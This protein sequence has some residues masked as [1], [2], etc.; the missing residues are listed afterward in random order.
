MVMQNVV[1]RARDA[2]FCIFT[3]RDSLLTVNHS[4]FL[5]LGGVFGRVEELLVEMFVIAE[6]DILILR[7]AGVPVYAEVFACFDPMGGT[8]CRTPKDNIY[9]MNGDPI[10]R[11]ISYTT[12][13]GIKVSGLAKAHI[14]NGRR[15][16]LVSVF[17]PDSFKGD[18]V[19]ET[20]STFPGAEAPK[21]MI[22]GTITMV[23]PG[24]YEVAVG[25]VHQYAGEEEEG[26]ET[27]I[28]FTRLT[29]T[30]PLLG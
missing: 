16:D 15:E 19:F 26:D 4:H 12:Q 17:P 23:G 29:I 14:E 9:A 27:L 25:S 21:T 1:Q 13:S 28:S 6:S 30:V 24:I 2:F 20:E 10:E 18:D 7:C 5:V 3:D 8:A 11:S 22:G